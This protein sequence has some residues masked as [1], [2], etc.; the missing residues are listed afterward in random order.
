MAGDGEVRSR[1]AL[2]VELTSSRR[3]AGREHISEIQRTRILVAMAEVACER[4]A[5]DASVGRVVDR[6]GISRRTFYELFEDRED[7][8]L[9]TLAAAIAHASV[10]VTAGYDLTAEWP[11]R[12]RSGLEAL[13]SF[14]DCEPAL[15]RLAVVQSLGAGTRALELRRSAIDR[16]VAAVDRGRETMNG[17]SSVTALTAE[18]VVGGVVS[19]IHGR[20]VSD[21]HGRL[22][23]LL[24]PLM[25]MIVLP[26]LGP[27]AARKELKRT[28]TRAPVGVPPAPGHPLKDLDMRLTYRTIRALAAVAANPGSSNRLIGDESGIED[29]GQVS[30]LLARLQKLGL[31]ENMRSGVPKG[32]SNVWSLTRSGEEVASALATQ[33]VAS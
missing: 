25:S 18:G 2:S 12:I 19:V 15:G 26:Y 4:G 17:S 5:G 32:T 21:E 14:L 31:V 30:K 23:E 33:A 29:Q 8:L 13:L 6:A 27:A 28:V 10:Y 7:C 9:A 20:L 3:G 16:M 22:A 1:G 24:N 11:E